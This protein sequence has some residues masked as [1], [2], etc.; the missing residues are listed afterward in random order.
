MWHCKCIFEVA[1][2]SIIASCCVLYIRLLTYQ[3]T[4]ISSIISTC[5]TRTGPSM[6]LTD[7]SNCVVVLICDLLLFMTAG[8]TASQRDQLRISKNATTTSVLSLQRWNIFSMRVLFVVRFGGLAVTHTKHAAV[9]WLPDG[10]SSDICQI[11][12][13]NSCENDWHNVVKSR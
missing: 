8:S 4:Q 9:E 10:H 7:S 11:L 3:H 13:D 1:F 6:R 12:L 2:C 5:M